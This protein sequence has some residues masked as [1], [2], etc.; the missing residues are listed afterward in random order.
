MKETLKEVFGPHFNE[1]SPA[2]GKI[3][4]ESKILEHIHLKNDY[5]NQLPHLFTSVNTSKHSELE[6][7]LEF[8]M[9]APIPPQVVHMNKA[10]FKIN[11]PKKNE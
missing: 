8:L 3:P 2:L 4:Y 10:L 7:K 11:S 6:K 1:R 5:R 9:P